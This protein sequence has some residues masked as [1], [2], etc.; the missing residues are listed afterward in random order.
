[1]ILVDGVE[2]DLGRINSNDIASI[3][4][5]KDAS[6]AA[7]YG[8]RGAFGVILVTTK[9]GDFDKAPTV[10]ADARFSVS[11]PTTSTDYETRG[12]YHAKIADLFMET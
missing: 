4:V 11:A 10:T 8:A 7:I 6:S 3:S 12:Y 9:S 2:T 1:M 5:L